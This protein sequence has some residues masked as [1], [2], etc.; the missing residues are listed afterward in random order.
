MQANRVLGPPERVLSDK[1]PYT[2]F[3]FCH[4]LSHPKP[5]S[6]IFAGAITLKLMDQP[7]TAR[8]LR[9]MQLLSSNVDY[10]VDDLMN[11]LDTSRRTIYRY[12]D[13]FKEAGF[14]VQNVHGNVWKLATLQ[15]KYGDLSKVVYFSEE[16]AFIMN[17]LL[18]SLDNTNAI[19][20]ELRRKLVAVYDFAAV[21]EFISKEGNSAKID[22]L[23]SAINNKKVVILK[24]YASSHSK[25]TKDY[26]VEPFKLNTNYIDIWAYDLADG[27]NKRF[28]TDRIGDVEILKDNWENED[29]HEAEALDAF[30]IHG[31]APV[32]VKLRMDMV[33]RNLLIEEYPLAEN[34]LRADG[35]A[36]IWEGDVN[37]MEGVGRF[38]LSLPDRIEVLEGE[39]V[40]G[41][42][43]EKAGYILNDKTL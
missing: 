6:I 38:V 9:L 28:K 12:I 30:R 34:G 2:R 36:F 19:K 40:K 17:R 22:A 42:L 8:M 1:R 16:E 18:D 24:N 11:I 5:K 39:E 31:N 21:G 29:A 10:T 15:N 26:R 3:G 32:H 23:N 14:A 4:F 7:K 33:A 37:G 25:K 41:Y 27:I 13:T 35:D 43:K 20:Q